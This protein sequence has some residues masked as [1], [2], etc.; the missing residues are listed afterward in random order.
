MVR[1]LCRP[2]AELGQHGLDLHQ[3]GLSKIPS[4]PYAP[5]RTDLRFGEFCHMSTSELCEWPAARLA[6][7]IRERRISPVEVIGA[8]LARIEAVN[9]A[10]NAF[11]FVYPEEALE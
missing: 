9:P 10:L 4:A 7:A 11:C 3:P 5:L 1:P 8:S 6:A 2:H